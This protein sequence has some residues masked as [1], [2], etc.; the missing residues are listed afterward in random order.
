MVAFISA[1]RPECFRPQDSIDGTFIVTSASK[2]ALYFCNQPHIAVSV[3][4]V[5]VVVIWVVRIGI[6]I[7]D[8][9]T[10][11]VD[12]D[13]RSIAE[14]AEMMCARHRP[15]R[16]TRLWPCRSGSRHHW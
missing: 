2:P 9:K 1:N 8:G 10:E 13:K 6:R 3:V 14:M 12:E 15:C 16:K 4:C 11:R 5:T 7:E